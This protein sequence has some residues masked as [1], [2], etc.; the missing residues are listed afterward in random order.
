MTREA[1]KHVA[2]EVWSLKYVNPRGG[3]PAST[4]VGMKRACVCLLLALTFIRAAHAI[5]KATN[6]G[7]VITGVTLISPELSQPRPNATVMIRGGRIKDIGTG[8][9]IGPHAQKIDGTGRFLIPGLIDSHVHL[10]SMAPLNDEVIES[11]PELLQAYRLQLPRSYLAFG[12]T[13][14]VDLDLKRETAAWFEAAPDRPKLCS[15]GRGVRIVGGYMALKPPKDAAAA[16][17]S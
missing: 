6:D 1:E 7:V 12:F 2:L 15:C 10:G 16:A 17:A 3:I 11:R 13:T 9:P 4:I 8:T 14:V 5:D